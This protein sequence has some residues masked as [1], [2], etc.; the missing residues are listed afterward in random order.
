MNVPLAPA[1]AVTSTPAP[2]WAVWSNP[3]FIRYCRARLRLQHLLIA[4]TLTLVVAA[5]CFF[6][7]RTF[8]LYRAHLAVAD[9]ER[10]PIVPLLILQ[11]FILF[12]FGTGQ[13]A[14]GMTGEADEGVLD[15]QRLSPM[16]PLAKVIG[17]LC[18]LPVR[19]WVMFGLT[20]PFTAWCVIR[21]GVDVGA[22]LPL[23]VV[24]VSS[25]VLY[26]LTGI[27]AGTVIK[28]RRW[29]F[30]FSIITVVLLYTVVPQVAK[31]GLVVFK[32][33]TMW[34]IVEETL[35]RL[36]PAGAGRVARELQAL[37]PNVRF[38]NLS[39]SDAVF[40]LFAQGVLIVTFVVMLWRRWRRSDSH[41]LGKAWAVGLFAW[42]HVMLLGCSLPLI[43]TPN[44]FFSRELRRRFFDARGFR[45]DLSEAIVMVGIYGFV[46]LLFMVTFLTMVTPDV[47]NQLR[48][49]RRAKKLGWLR[50]P[51]F[52]DP[53][54]ALPF[55][56]AMA[57]IGAGA[58]AIFADTLLSSHWFAQ[59]MPAHTFPVFLMVLAGGG[60]AYHALLEGWGGRA[61]F[62]ATVFGGLLPPMV[63]GILGSAAD[64]LF[65][66][67]T[68]LAGISPATAPF[69]AAV[70]LSPTPIAAEVNRAVPRAF[71][72][73]QGI[74]LLLAGWLV[75][76]LIAIHRA[77]RAAVN[78]ETPPA[79]P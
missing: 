34:P 49:L 3:I 17:Y 75:V 54:G 28:N 50:V 63:A 64:S 19:E 61:P 45:P 18:G 51:R 78:G 29:A 72:F 8:A 4:G 31:F 13:A 7:P 57:V 41:L 67:S 10:T 69:Y 12:A 65:T 35:P 68:W 32:Y 46:T 48:G 70:T 56:L 40:T 15:Y 60:V 73:W 20:L 79:E 38:F 66:L 5:M 62:F 58:W 22:W 11:G 6:L 37:T 53:A 14:G 52:A 47:E 26:H 1:S 44:I 25:A 36:L 76:R 24:L 21:G 71:W 55:V 23:Y 39:F 2:A 33:F 74:T 42:L 30:L 27:V 16:T 9:A 43:D 77:R 59:P